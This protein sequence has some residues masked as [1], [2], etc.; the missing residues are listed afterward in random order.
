MRISM[1]GLAGTFLSAALLAACGGASSGRSPTSSAL[2]VDANGS[3]LALPALPQS[4]EY[5]I[6]QNGARSLQSAMPDAIKQIQIASDSCCYMAVAPA[7]NHIYVSSGINIKGNHTTV[8]DGGGSS[9]SIL[10]TVKGFGGANNMDSK[11]QNV[12]LPGLHG[13]D[14]EVYSGTTLSKVT[15]VSL[16]DCPIT[17][18]VDGK[19]RYAW[20]AAQCGAGDDPV[21]AI[22]ADTYA[23]VAGPIGS[24]G[25]MGGTSVLDPV[26]GKYY[27]DNSVGTFEINPLAS[28]TLSPT[29]FGLALGVNSTTDVLY[30]RAANRLNIVNGRSEKVTKTVHLSYT[31]GFMAVNRHLNHIYLSAGQNSIEVREGSAGKLLK[32]ITLPS[33]IGIGSLGADNTRSRIYAIG[34]SGSNYYLYQIKDKY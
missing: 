4:V 28:F 5:P 27:F 13:A 11:T 32:T 2:T 26:T 14:V 25:V 23:V 7:L 17:S 10:A 1:S 29:S 18:W 19:R 22:N 12:W 31:P 33:G 3:T 20:V 34:T 6:T 9:F 24:G 15:T 8:V 21:W 16:S 30:A